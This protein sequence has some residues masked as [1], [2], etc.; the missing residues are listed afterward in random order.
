MRR[1]YILMAE[2]EPPCWEAWSA[3]E[4]LE[5]AHATKEK[6]RRLF[7]AVFFWIEAMEV[8]P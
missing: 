1:V 6:N 3:H 8:K 2:T 4:T 7:P 5:S